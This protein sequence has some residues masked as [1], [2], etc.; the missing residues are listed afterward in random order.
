MRSYQYRGAF[1]APLPIEKNNILGL[2]S[3]QHH[4]EKFPNLFIA[5]LPT[6]VCTKLKASDRAVCAFGYRLPLF[7]LG[8]AEFLK[9]SHRIGDGTVFLKPP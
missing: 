9:D 5:P 4:W 8:V 7:V 6:V 3:S 2:K 1:I